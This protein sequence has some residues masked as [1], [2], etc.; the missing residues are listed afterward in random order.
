[1][2]RA[3]APILWITAKNRTIAPTGIYTHNPERFLRIRKSNIDVFYSV[4][5]TWSKPR[6][7]GKSYAPN[8]AS[9]Q[10]LTPSKPN[11][12]ANASAHA[13]SAQK[14]NELKQ[15]KNYQNLKDCGLLPSEHERARF[16]ASD[17]NT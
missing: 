13:G 2:T 5:Y 15:T 4:N 12:F 9:L 11:E 16:P 3:S 7:Y 14:Y 6:S 17:S 8:V 10:S 1:M